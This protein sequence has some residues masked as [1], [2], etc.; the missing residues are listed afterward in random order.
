MR[1]DELGGRLK[2]LGRLDGFTFKARQPIRPRVTSFCFHSLREANPE[3]LVEKHQKPI[4][5]TVVECV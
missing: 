4:E 2:F 1:R 3:L 5:G